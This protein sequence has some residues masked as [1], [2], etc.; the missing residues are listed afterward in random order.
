VV[1]T[2][3]SSQSIA[4]VWQPAIVS[5][6]SI[7]QA[8]PSSQA[9]GAVW[10]P[11][12]GLHESVVQAL[13]SLQFLAGNVQAPVVALQVSTVHRFVSAHL[14]VWVQAPVAGSQVSMVQILLSL[15]FV[16]VPAQVPP[17]QVSPEV[18]GLPSSQ[19]PVLLVC[20]QLL[21]AASQE[22][23]VQ[24]FPSSQEAGQTGPG[25]TPITLK[26]ALKPRNGPSTMP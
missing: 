15:Q 25:G 7:V 8:L 2:V 3:P 11:V 19:D 12:I 6:E 1:Q 22:S 9:I 21:V 4:A 24:T 10:Q 16:P 20:T 18:Q 14:G 5:H 13:L 17:A 26:L 23:S